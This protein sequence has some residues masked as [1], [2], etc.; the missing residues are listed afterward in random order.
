[1]SEETLTIEPRLPVST[2]RRGDSLRHEERSTQIKRHYV[3]KVF[4]RDTEERH[5][6]IGASVVDQDIERFTANDRR[7][8]G[9]EIGDV[10]RDR[11]SRPP[12]WRIDSVTSSISDFVRAARTT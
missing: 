12:S 11:L 4:D 2:I 8:S 6:P 9:F 5:R 3:I 7:N 10:Q 1:M